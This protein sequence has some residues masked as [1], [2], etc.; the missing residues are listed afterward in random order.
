MKA[1]ETLERIAE[2]SITLLDKVF[3]HTTAE[4]LNPKIPLNSHNEFYRLK[5]IR[6]NYSVQGLGS[7]LSSIGNYIF[8]LSLFTK[9]TISSFELASYLSEGGPLDPVILREYTEV[10][11]FSGI[12]AISIGSSILLLRISRKSRER[13]EVLMKKTDGYALKHGLRT[14]T[15]NQDVEN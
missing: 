2:S 4:D 6:L 3:H 7:I 14:A 12:G 8:G 1:K 5:Q 9:A 11:T 10:G 13:Y 15:V